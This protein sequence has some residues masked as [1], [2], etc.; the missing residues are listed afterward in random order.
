MCKLWQNWAANF[1]CFPKR[2]HNHLGEKSIFNGNT[3]WPDSWSFSCRYRLLATTD[4]QTENWPVLSSKLKSRLISDML[5]FFPSP[6]W[7]VCPQ[8]ADSGLFQSKLTCYERSCPVTCVALQHV[9]W[10]RPTFPPCLCPIE[11]QGLVVSCDASC[12]CRIPISLP[13]QKKCTSKVRF[14]SSWCWTNIFSNV[15]CSGAEVTK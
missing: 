2:I 12:R 8:A 13:T 14:L 9:W 3:L 6:Q 1:K 10:Y 11:M 5:K 7:L 15:G 4:R